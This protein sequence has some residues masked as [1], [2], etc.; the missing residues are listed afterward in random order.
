MAGY[1]CIFIQAEFRQNS[2]K[3]I[4]SPMQT[5]APP[6]TL[7][8]ETTFTEL[9]TAL[10]SELRS[11][12]D[13]TLQ[14]IGED[15]QFVRFNRGRVR[16]T[17]LVTDGILTLTLMSDQSTAY[18]ELPFWGDGATDLPQ[19]QAALAELREEL[20]QLPKDPHL[21]LPTGD[22]GSR[23]SQTGRLLPPT[24]TVAAI[25]TGVNGLD[26]TG[27]Y[28]AGSLVRAYADSAG[29]QH[30]FSTETF[31]L[32]YSLFTENGH[33]VK[34]GYAGRDWQQRDYEANM[35]AAKT[36]L[37]RMAQ[38]PRAIAR[39]K[40]KTYLAPAAVA[41][42][43][44]MFSWGAVSE[45]A[46]QRGGSALLPLR[47]GEKPMSPLFYLSE[48]FRHGLVPRF[49]DLGEV[50][51]MELPLI[52]AGELVNTL[53]SSRTAREYN[54]VANGATTWEGM[55]SPDVAPGSLPTQDVLKEL[56][57]GLYLSNLHYLNWSDRPSGRITGMTRYACFWVEDGEIVA[58]IENLRFDESLYHIFG[59]GLLALTDTQEF[60]PE[61][62]TY[63]YRDL[64]GIW[65][66]GI[67]VDGFTY[68]L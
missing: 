19:L 46:M 51:P 16:Q 15:S 3:E 59:Y 34:G 31:C 27:F 60:I 5:T 57:T 65:T 42:L 6:A 22:A 38:P 66:P 55:R 53:V 39:G 11:G 23:T 24:E 63:G 36:Q 4:H 32:D 47:S 56:G 43:I 35:A 58:P 9:V 10:R 12:E 50:A 29:Q 61:T 30:W 41:D 20:P 68:T 18:R 37:E 54:L 21:V 14:L 44:S 2:S 7:S 33:A 25:L 26:F 1:S 28:A 62:G 40:Y 45:G 48:N 13:F 49:N 64:G 52:A 17:G 67:L 8:L